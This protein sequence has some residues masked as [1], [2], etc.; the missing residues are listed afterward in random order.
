MRIGKKREYNLENY[1]NEKFKQ[2]RVANENTRDQLQTSQGKRKRRGGEMLETVY[3][4]VFE[5]PAEWPKDDC[6]HLQSIIKH[7]KQSQDIYNGRLTMLI[8]ELI[9]PVCKSCKLPIKFLN[10]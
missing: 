2:G 8:L 6:T 5:P 3:L 7:V 1:F 4:L 10:M 9:M